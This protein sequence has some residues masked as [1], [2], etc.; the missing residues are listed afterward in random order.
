M[1]CLWT[2]SPAAEAGFYPKLLCLGGIRVTNLQL[3]LKRL[4]LALQLTD[5]VRSLSHVLNDFALQVMQ[6]EDGDRK[7]Q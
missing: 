6:P 2:S 7:Q 3:P 4:D 5:D 1:D